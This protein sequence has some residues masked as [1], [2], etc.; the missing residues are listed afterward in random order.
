MSKKKK[1]VI[2]SEDEVAEFG[3][4]AESP[5]QPAP[6][7]P[8]GTAETDAQTEAPAEAEAVNGAEQWKEKCLRAKADLANYQ[9]R[10]AKDQAESRRNA[11]V[12]LAKALLPITLKFATGSTASGNRTK[13]R[14]TKR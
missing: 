2:P 6:E 4:A 1:I 5:D 7:P 13:L 9:R 11:H 10:A 12:E 8:A 3:G 14:H